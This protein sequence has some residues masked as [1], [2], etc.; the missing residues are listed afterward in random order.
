MPDWLA[1]ILLGIIEGLTEFLPVSS[2]GH[3]LI[4]EN[5]GLLPK[6]SDLFNVVI[7]SGAVLAVQTLK[8][9][10][11]LLRLGANIGGEPLRAAYPEQT[12]QAVETT[13]KTVYPIYGFHDTS[14][15]E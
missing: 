3:L 4:V 5:T 7:Q 8:S 2:T 10:Y 15:A 6:Q 9:L 13:L 1:A 12:V 11:V 14:A